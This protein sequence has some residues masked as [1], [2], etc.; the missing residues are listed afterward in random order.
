MKVK[1]IPNRITTSISEVA[2]NH[3]QLKPLYER[4]KVFLLAE[5]GHQ[6]TTVIGCKTLHDVIYWCAKFKTFEKSNTEAEDR[7]LFC[8][9]VV[10]PENIPYSIAGMTQTLVFA[11]DWSLELCNSVKEAT[12]II[13]KLFETVADLTMDE[14]TVVIGQEMGE[15][16]KLRANAKIEELMNE[17]AN[18]SKN[19]EPIIL[20]ETFLPMMRR[21][22]T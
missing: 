13:E 9:T 21:N 16:I 12:E 1:D 5:D 20:P 22:I 17:M 8:G 18:Q 4:K 11:Q 6:E 15:K 14:V 10:D 2:V 3:S 19:P 7:I